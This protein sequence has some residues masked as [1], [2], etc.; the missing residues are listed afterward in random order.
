EGDVL[1]VAVGTDVGTIDAL[2]ISG[3]G[4]EVAETYDYG[5]HWFRARLWYKIAGSSEP[6]SY[7]VTQGFNADGVAILA[8]VG[9]PDGPP[10]TEVLGGSE[11]GSTVPTP[12]VT[13]SGPVSVEIRWAFGV[14]DDEGVSWSP[15][16]GFVELVDALSTTYTTGTAAYRD[17]EDDSPTSTATFTANQSVYF[18]LG[19][20][21]A[22]SGA[23]AP[24]V[25][26]ATATPGAVQAQSQ[27][28]AP[29]VSAGS[30]AAPGVVQAA[31]T[32]P[33]PTV[34]AG[35]TAS[36]GAVSASA[37]VPAPAAGA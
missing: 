2:S 7:T 27:V 21:A 37:S 16:S 32:V 3:S 30:S 28:P 23:A 18:Q 31:A 36:P 6:E 8:A 14:P 11:D 33:S 25:G 17:L 9:N 29:G 1:L 20:T 10:V 35:S 13:P 15:P 19:F 5:A 4:W 26:D 12:G 22:V 34:G 24:P